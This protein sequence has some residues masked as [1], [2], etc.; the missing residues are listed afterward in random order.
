ML[1]S[2]TEFA[3][4]II[5]C[6]RAQTKRILLSTAGGFLLTFMLFAFVFLTDE[7][8]STLPLLERHRLAWV[9]LWHLPVFKRLFE[10]DE[11]FVSAALSFSVFFHSILIYTGLSW[12]SKFRMLS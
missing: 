7:G 9:L 12:Q 2:I 4:V 3:L 10:S 5:E 8:D 6:L 1:S 11:A